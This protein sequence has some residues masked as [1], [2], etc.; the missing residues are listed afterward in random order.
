QYVTTKG[1]TRLYNVGAKLCL[2]F[3][4]AATGQVATVRTCDGSTS[5]KYAASQD[6]SS[7]L[8]GDKDVSYPTA[9]EFTKVNQALATLKTTA[10]AQYQI[11]QQQAPIASKQ[12]TAATTAEQ[13]AYAIADA[14]GAPRG[15]GLLSGQQ[16]A[17]VVLASSAA[18]TAL[19]HAAATANQATGASV[20]D[21]Q[22]LNAEAATQA[23]G[24][25]TAF[26]LAGAQEADAQAK[27]EAAGAAQQAKNAA[28]EATTAKQALATAQ[29]AEATAQQAAATAHTKRL[30]AEAQQQTAAKEKANA[31]AD[32]AKAA[33]DP[34]AAERDDQAAQAALATAQSAEATAQQ[35]SAAAQQADQDAT[36]A[37]QA[38]WDAQS[39]H[40]ALEAKAEAADAHADAEASGDDATASRAAADQADQAADTAGSDADAAQQHADAAS[41][42]AEAADAAAT[43]AEAAA[44]R[45]QSD[46]DGAKA[47]KATADA[48]LRTDEAAA[49][50]AVQAA[51][52]ASADADAAKKDADAAE[53]DAMA[54]Q[55]DAVEAAQ[56]AQ[57]AQAGAATTAGYAY[58]T[59]QAATAATEA[60]QQVTDPANDAI[61]LG[62]PYVDHDSSAGLAVLSGQAAKT[63]A[64]QQQAAAQAKSQQAAQAAQD[65]QDL[66][67]TAT[68]DAKAAA[69]V[70]AD[71][72]VQAAN[73]AV[74]A[75]HALASAAEAQKYAAQAQATVAQT[76]AYVAQATADSAAAQVAA[77]T[78]A[79]DAADA[80]AS[81][82][83]AEQDADA[84][85]QAASDARNAAA[86]AKQAAAAADAAATAA[87]AAAKDAEAQAESAQQAATLAQQQANATS[88]TNGGATGTPGVY[89]TQTITPIGNPEPQNPCNL[90]TINSV[91][92]VTFRLTFT[93][94]VDFYLCD[95]T[96][97]TPAELDA[98]GCPA[99]DSVFLG[100]QTEQGH[101]DI[102]RSFTQLDIATMVDQ[103]FLTGLW[104]A[105][106]ADF[107]HCAHGSVSG[108]F[109]AATWFVP[110]SKILKAVDA[111]KALNL[112]LHTGVDLADAWKVVDGL[113]L[114]AQIADALRAEVEEDE[115][116]LANCLTNSFLP[117][118]QVLMADGSYR[119]MSSV[120]VGDRVMS[121]DPATGAPRPETVTDTFAHPANGRLLTLALVGGGR[122]TTTPGHRILIAGRGWVLA[123]DLHVGDR[124]GTGRDAGRV[125]AAVT[126]AAGGGRTVRDFTVA[127]THD[128]YVLAGT[129]AILVHNCT[130]LAG[131][132]AQFPDAAHT[133]ADHV[134]ISPADAISKAAV[135]SAKQG[136]DV[137]TCVWASQDL[138]QQAVDQTIANAVKK[139]PKFFTNWFAKIGKGQASDTLTLTG[140]LGSDG[141]SLGKVYRR[142]GSNTAASNSYTVVLKRLKD[143]KPSGFI[144]YT[145]YPNP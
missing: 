91:C 9:A 126:T 97:L 6:N 115:A 65:A 49:A 93:A 12:A 71:A 113:K 37:T 117:G 32:E 62:A 14:A 21:S 2:G 10:D 131:D 128:F 11:V 103:A 27:A 112:A 67:N 60:A 132:E 76:K 13:Q 118:A 56:S 141:S 80:R 144:V 64:E 53:V 133:L 135:E 85:Q 143:H 8:D 122:L 88:V 138:A 7:T 24:G 35:K 78:A 104:S 41:A 96:T 77:D 100:S 38:A 82:D 110:E 124:L 121:T 25:Q 114:D 18:L 106:K 111:I 31:A 140:K 59:A 48:A 81:A 30:A 28:A 79:G 16:E 139:N 120:Q 94:T 137:P 29:A 52:Q 125:L 39:R 26:K 116:V 92:N 1:V 95:D 129:A 98:G 15:R 51:Q 130:N 108:C 46:A 69:V 40:N 73:A 3:P 83:S 142:D 34:A 17:Q 36:T 101:Q 45:A 43:R 4:T 44:S 22:T 99:I 109:W 86:T 61:Q 90:P 89:T 42:A 66:A 107:V 102:V 72:A 5:Q 23:S 50:T 75:Q 54:A 19:S 87:E 136:R 105:L 47:A 58:T 134:R 20:A 63:I 84:A 70:A 55:Q 33:Q 127:G 145:S 68:G 57:E 74:S 119:T 123:S